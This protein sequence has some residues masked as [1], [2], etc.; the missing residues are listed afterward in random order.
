MM[1]ASRLGVVMARWSR[2]MFFVIAGF[3]FLVWPDAPAHAALVRVGGAQAPCHVSARYNWAPAFPAID[4]AII[5]PPV[6]RIWTGAVN[7]GPNGAAASVIHNPGAPACDPG[8]GPNDTPL[9][10]GVGN[11]VPAA[12][13]AGVSTRVALQAAQVSHG[14]HWDIGY[15]RATVSVNAAGGF[16]APTTID[17][18]A[19]HDPN[20]LVRP[21]FH[22][23]TTRNLAIT[24][25]P[26]FRD[27]D[28]PTKIIEG[29][30]RN[31]GML[32]QNQAKDYGKLPEKDANGNPL[33]SYIVRAAGSPFTETHL[34]FLGLVDGV[35]SEL[36]LGAA[37]VLFLSGRGEI[38]APFLR[39][40][41]GDENGAELPLNL[42]VGV[43]LTQWVGG[44][45]SA[46][47]G[48]VHDVVGGLSDAL[49]GLYLS[50][51]PVTLGLAGWTSDAPYSGRAGVAG[52]IDGSVPEPAALALFG[53]A[54]CGF[55]TM[56]R[57]AVA[58]RNRTIIHLARALRV[59]VVAA[60]PEAAEHVP[61]LE[62]ARLP[63]R[64]KCF[65]P[66]LHIGRRTGRP[67]VPS[68]PAA[69]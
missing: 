59:D 55:G 61:A 14:P 54:L 45:F 1:V 69:A 24:I 30:P 10:L 48:T 42:Y 52:Q 4:L 46:P 34:A 17:V 65:V 26:D 51:S 60:G 37:M 18:A 50:L 33:A 58:R 12:P 41:E 15:L 39:P 29:K 2:C 22:N 36:D 31:E 16:V 20:A 11:I 43:D 67:R 23:D 57:R 32:A 40:W 63:I 53:V 62:L 21:S 38:L 47:S 13:A 25:T 8:H 5:T 7:A 35:F 64:V 28:D 49:P 27:K 68:P 66:C 44:G 56:Q 9:V 3:A 6:A 19:K